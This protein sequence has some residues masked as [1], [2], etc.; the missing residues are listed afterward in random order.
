MPQDSRAKCERQYGHLKEGAEKRG[1]SG[2]AGGGSL[3]PDGEQGARSL[4]GAE[5]GEQDVRAGQEVRPAA[6]R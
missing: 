4:R 5:D 3:G 6:R 1:T 2:G